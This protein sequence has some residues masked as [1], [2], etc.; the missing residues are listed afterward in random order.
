[1]KNATG[2]PTLR[3]FPISDGNGVRIKVY[4]PWCDNWH[5]HSLSDDLEKGGISRRRAHCRQK[6]SPFYE[7]GYMIALIRRGELKEI[8]DW[9][10]QLKVAQTLMKKEGGPENA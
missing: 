1:M 6:M 3:G 5:W 8:S 7:S 4:C 9:L 2:L 10:K